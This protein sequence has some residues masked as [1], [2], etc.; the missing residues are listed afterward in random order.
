MSITPPGNWGGRRNVPAQEWL[1]QVCA[2][3]DYARAKGVVRR[4]IKPGNV[5]IN[6]GSRCARPS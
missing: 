3:L 2:A 6:L 5:L 4:G 1:R